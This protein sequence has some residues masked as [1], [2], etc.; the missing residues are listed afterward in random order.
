VVLT[1]ADRQLPAADLTHPEAVPRDQEADPTDPVV[2]P[3]ALDRSSRH[4][5]RR[6]SGPLPRQVMVSQV[7]CARNRLVTHSVR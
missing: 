3:M 6:S 2:D 4:S 7:P 5:P 1:E